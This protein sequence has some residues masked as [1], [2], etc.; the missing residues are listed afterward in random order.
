MTRTRTLMVMALITV[1]MCGGASAQTS[2][3]Q[4]ALYPH[5]LAQVNLDARID[6]L[7]QRIALLRDDMRMFTGE[8]KIQAMS[9]LI[10]ALIERQQLVERRQHKHLMM[11]PRVGGMPDARAPDPAPA[12]D[13]EQEPESMCSPYI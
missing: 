6:L 10:E 2:P 1:L 13:S 12:P 7:D 3:G 4:K 11:Q 5:A 9:D 8:L